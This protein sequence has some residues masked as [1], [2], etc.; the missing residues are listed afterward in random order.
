MSVEDGIMID[1]GFWNPSM[2]AW[3]FGTWNLLYHGEAFAEITAN[4]HFSIQIIGLAQAGLH[5]AI[6]AWMVDIVLRLSWVVIAKRM[7]NEFKACLAY[8]I[9]AQLPDV[10]YEV[11]CP[12]C[13]SITT[14]DACQLPCRHVFHRSCI[15]QWART[16]EGHGLNCP[17]CR[18]VPDLKSSFS[19]FPPA[20][21]YSNHEI[22]VEVQ[23]AGA[24]E[25]QSQQQAGN[26]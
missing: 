2:A 6:Y 20:S 16:N 10:M 9:L 19:A 25:N 8:R 18:A 13:L 11:E 7:R 15:T 21:S 1:V 14:T 26:P 3:A 4:S 5:L 23:E 17:V 24:Q 12:I 22:V